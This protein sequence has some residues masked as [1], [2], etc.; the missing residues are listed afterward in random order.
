MKIHTSSAR[1]LLWKKKTRRDPR[2]HEKKHGGTEKVRGVFQ[3]THGYQVIQFVTFLSPIVGGHDSPLKRS[4]KL[5]I[6]KTV[7]SR[8][9]WEIFFGGGASPKP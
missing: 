9:G 8:I 3:F 6:P 5:T 7:T 4:R 2:N 1:I